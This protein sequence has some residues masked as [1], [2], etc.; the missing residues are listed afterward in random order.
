MRISVILFLAL[1]LSLVAGTFAVTVSYYTDSACK[2]SVASPFNGVS[3]PVDVSVN[4][5]FLAFNNGSTVYAKATLCN[6]TFASFDN[7]N[8]AACAVKI[9]SFVYVTN[10]CSNR[11]QASMPNNAG[12]AMFTCASP[13][14][15]AKPPSSASIAVSTSVA[16]AFGALAFVLI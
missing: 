12:S 15:P 1:A 16:A 13:I 11:S 10:M 9:A 2:N 6:S 8:D 5:C 3:Q 7:F 4:Q 14:S